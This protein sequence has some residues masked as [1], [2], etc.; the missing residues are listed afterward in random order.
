MN[1]NEIPDIPT[2]YPEATEMIRKCFIFDVRKR[3]SAKD[4]LKES[5]ITKW[6]GNDSLTT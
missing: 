4:L 5:F 6:N 2:K 1:C 3:P